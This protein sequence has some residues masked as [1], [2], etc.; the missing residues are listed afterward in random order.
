MSEWHRKYHK[1]VATFHEWANLWLVRIMYTKRWILTTFG[2]KGTAG[3][4]VNVG[5]FINFFFYTAQC[6][7][8]VKNRRRLLVPSV[9]NLNSRLYLPL[10]PTVNERVSAW[11]TLRTPKSIPEKTNKT[12]R[13]FTKSISSQSHV[14][15]VLRGLEGFVFI[16]ALASTRRVW[17]YTFSDV[18]FE[19]CW[20]TA[21]SGSEAQWA[22]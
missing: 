22:R 13:A 7:T 11:P 10:F 21:Y 14:N 20:R 3:F 8:S 6:C 16:T 12:S 15:C 9:E 2:Q 19:L 18:L 1:K 4:Q 17:N 5:S